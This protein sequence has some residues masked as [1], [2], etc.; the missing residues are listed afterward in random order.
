MAALGPKNREVKELWQYPMAGGSIVKVKG[1]L[2]QIRNSYEQFVGQFPE[3]YC[4]LP[5]FAL[6]VFKIEQVG[7]LEGFTHMAVSVGWPKRDEERMLTHYFNV[8]DKKQFSLAEEPLEKGRGA[9]SKS[10]LFNYDDLACFSPSWK[11]KLPEYNEMLR[12]WLEGHAL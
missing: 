4:T 6:E 8:Q 2:I 10:L 11:H 9:H 5:S 7:G 12:P 1:R 3:Q